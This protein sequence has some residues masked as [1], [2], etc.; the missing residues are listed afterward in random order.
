MEEIRHD[1][2]SKNGD[3]NRVKRTR[4]V[5]ENDNS[6]KPT[7]SIS[8]ADDDEY[9]NVAITGE[10]IIEDYGETYFN[11]WKIGVYFAKMFGLAMTVA[12]PAIIL[13]F[14]LTLLPWINEPNSGYDIVN[15]TYFNRWVVS[16]MLSLCITSFGTW[17]IALYTTMIK[18]IKQVWTRN[19]IYV[20][21]SITIFWPLLYMTMISSGVDVWYYYMDFLFF[22]L[23][24]LP[25]ATV[26]GWV[27]SDGSWS[28][29]IRFGIAEFIVVIGALGYMFFLYP[30]FHKISNGAKIAWR[31]LLHPVIF[32]SLL[33]TPSRWLLKG[34]A[35]N[36]ETSR[37]IILLST[38]A[39]FH[40][41]TIGRMILFTIDDTSVIVICTVLTCAEEIIGRVTSPYRDKLI[42]KVTRGRFKDQQEH[43]NER[44]AEISSDLLNT[45]M[46]IE[47][48]GIFISFA[49]MMAFQ[50]YG[51][52]F[53]F[54]TTPMKHGVFNL[55]LQVL[56]E[57]VVNI[58]CGLY[59][60]RF[61]KND[62]LVSWNNM[63]TFP[64][65]MFIIYGNC[66]MG[67]LGMIYVTLQLPRAAFCTA[68]NIFTC[69][70]SP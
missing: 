43:T 2:I 34:T 64:Y 10:S 21:I 61:L 7:F 13:T 63:I 6:D 27:I 45:R 58:L 62:L 67:L 11:Y 56:L 57:I 28:F 65:V 17:F 66:T 53:T 70:Y 51:Y 42:L 40:T 33:L 44:L 1:V 20:Y 41:Y 14:L 16:G 8:P 32:E 4:T 9:L 29:A 26:A 55:I 47:F 49:M 36:E 23:G 22:F 48:S 3:P 18:G 31:L 50:G 69:S 35:T 30:T 12:A 46:L 38:H 39:M 25:M 37:K 5:N 60:I 15:E 59:E 52:L 54:N 68:N 24:F 19:R